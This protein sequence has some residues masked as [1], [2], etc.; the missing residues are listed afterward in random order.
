VTGAISVPVPILAEGHMLLI[1]S[2]K[3]A[4]EEVKLLR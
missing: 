2:L 1:S 4:G 3:V